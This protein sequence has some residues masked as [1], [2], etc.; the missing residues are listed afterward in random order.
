MQYFS[1]YRS[2]L[3]MIILAADDEGLIGSWFDGQKYFKSGLTDDAVKKDT[4][5]LRSAESWLDLYFSGIRPDFTPQL[6]LIGTDF[7]EAVW[8]KLLQIPYGRTTTYG[9]I[10]K[11]IAGENSKGKASPQAVGGAVG[12][13]PVSIIVPCHRVVG[14]K[15]QLTGYAGGLDR[16][17]RLLELE[18][19]I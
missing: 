15:G 2:P 19:A 5:I 10:A 11:E 16:K 4:E 18:G 8:N 1:E 14:S 12:H 13:N 7:Q 9:N 6:H 17:Q 3:G